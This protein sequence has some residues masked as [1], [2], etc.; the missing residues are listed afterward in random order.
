MMPIPNPNS[1]SSNSQSSQ[2][3]L[4]IHTMLEGGTCPYRAW[5]LYL[6]TETYG[7]TGDLVKKL[8][9]A[10]EFLER[11][12]SH[13][14]REELYRQKRFSLD[15]AVLLSDEVLKDS[16]ADLESDLKETAEIVFGIFGLAKHQS[17]LDDLKRE[18]A[19]GDGGARND[20]FES[21]F[22]IIRA[23]IVNFRTLQPIKD[24]KTSFYNKLVST[25]GTVVR[26]SHVRPICTWLAFECAT[27]LLVHSVHQPCG[28]FLE[29]MKCP[30]PACRSRRFTPLRSHRQTV[31]VDWQTIRLQE[32]VQHESGRVP[33]TIECE[34][35]ED[36]C[37]SAVPGDVIT[38]TGILK[39]L[40]VAEKGSRDKFMFQLYLQALSIVNAKTKS[41]GGEGGDG[42][43]E[44]SSNCGVE[45]T[46]ADYSMVQEIHA[47]DS[48]IFKLVVHS[49]CPSI[50]GHD[51]VKAGLVLGLF[52]GANKQQSERS[53]LSVRPDPHVSRLRK[54]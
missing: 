51:L 44:R 46:L 33:R 52:G 13:L 16:W 43:R 36:L 50:Y 34:L 24:L 39:N 6:P 53:H 42:G 48:M 9:A 4:T 14:G 47:M 3:Q 7:P 20:A 19:A 18:M 30:G 25:R 40:N 10:R 37:D 27:C 26:I 17:V 31:T 35:V 23:R 28:K 49:L 8:K 2:Q 32:I 15:Q 1:S 11:T 12:T 54:I 22:P 41:A 38:L 45:F 29:P 5:K 21:R